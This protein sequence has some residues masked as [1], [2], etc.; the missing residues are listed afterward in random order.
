[1]AE[2]NDWNVNAA[3]NNSAPPDGWPENMNYSEVNDSARENMAVVRRFFGDLNGSRA[4]AG[5]VNVYTVTL[6][7][8]YTAYFDG[9]LFACT[10]PITNTAINPTLNVNG[11]GARTIKDYAGAAIGVGDLVAGGL[12]MFAD[13]GTNLR[14]IANL[15]AANVARTDVNETFDGDVTVVGSINGDLNGDVTGN[16]SG[17]AATVT[18]NANLTGQVTS[19]GNAA[20]MHVS[21]ITGQ[22]NTDSLTGTDELLVNDGGALRRMDLIRLITGMADIGAAIVGTDELM[23]S[24]AGQLRRTDVSRIRDYFIQQANTYTQKQTFNAEVEFA[25]KYTEDADSYS[26]TTGTKTLNLN[27]ATYFYA[28]GDMGTSTI[29]FAFSNPAA[30]GKVSSFTLEMLGADGATINWPAS[31]E[32][33]GGTEPTWTAGTDI[34]SFITRDGGATWRGFPGGLNF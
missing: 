27:N 26:V 3:N 11:I 12:Y 2:L 31:V 14:V 6:N 23:I 22:A 8:S 25:G 20:S 5:A 7:A 10:I 16:V 28:S 19:V 9:L 29:T 21:A 18:T 34:V 4:A 24:D 30:S 32:W 1:M 15:G 17:N 13:D 33:A